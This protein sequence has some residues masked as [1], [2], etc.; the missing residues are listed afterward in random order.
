MFSCEPVL[1]SSLGRL[2]IKMSSYQYRNPH[3]KDKTVSRPSYLLHGNPIHGKDGLD[4]ETGPCRVSLL[5]M[6]SSSHVDIVVANLA[7][8]RHQ[9]ICCSMSFLYRY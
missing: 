9:G 3:V 5:L 7:L 1:F 8:D 6:D 2:N 4:I